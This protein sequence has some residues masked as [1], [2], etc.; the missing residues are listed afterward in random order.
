[1]KM[2]RSRG[3]PGARRGGAFTIIELL[4]VVAII[5]LLIG[6]LV[7]SL[8][9][10]RAHARN[11]RTRAT[12]KSVA[13]GLE[14]FVGENPEDTRR[15]GGYPPSEAAEDEAETGT[16]L[17]FGA[18]WMVRYLVGKDLKGYVP[19]R[20][21]PADLLTPPPPAGWAQ[22]NWYDDPENNYVSQVPRAGPYLQPDG[23]TLEEPSKL[24]GAPETPPP[25]CDARTL[26]QLV[27]LDAWG[28]P[29]LYYAANARYADRPDATIASREGT[30]PGIYTMKDNALF[31]GMKEGSPVYPAW[32]L[33]LFGGDERYRLA[34]FGTDPP[35]VASLKAAAAAGQTHIFPYYVLSKN[36]WESSGQQ[37]AVPYRKSA[38]LLITA[39]R[40]GIYGTKDD[41]TNFE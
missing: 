40:D 10:A 17:I 4:V 39:G 5:V 21:V 3:G 13:D 32:D 37:S 9:A 33:N 6:L 38:Y 35:T 16:Q 15:T 24:P 25:G 27:A 11:V 8:S 7:P 23:L 19:K 41:V 26:R 29:I 34:E 20:H 28:Y 2:N 18:Q 36:V 1:M 12:L 30:R 31:T 22:K 14:M